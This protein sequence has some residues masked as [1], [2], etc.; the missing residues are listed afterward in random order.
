LGIPD[1]AALEKWKDKLEWENIP[2]AKFHE[3]DWDG[4]LTAMAALGHETFFAKLPL[5]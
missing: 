2:H 5:L 1:K 3:P 4:E